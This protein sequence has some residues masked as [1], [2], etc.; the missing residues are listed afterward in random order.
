M[1][2][3]KQE[4]PAQ[5]QILDDDGGLRDDAE[6]LAL[7]D[8]AIVDMYTDM[9]LARRFD[10]RVVSLN[11]QGRIGSFP[12]MYGHE[13]AQIASAHAL[14]DEDWVIPSYRDHGALMAQGFPLRNILLYYMG[15]EAGNAVPDD[16]NALPINGSVGSQ[17]LHAT[18]MAWA[19][20]LRDDV[21]SVYCCYFGDGATSQGFAQEAWNFAG[22]FDTPNVFFCQNNGWAIS[23]PR[24][25]QT[26]AETI[27]QKAHA[28][29]FDGVQVDG[30]DPLAVYRITREAVRRAK[31]P[32]PDQSRPMLIEAVLYRLGAHS[33]A[34]DPSKYRPEDEVEKWRERD[35]LVRFEQFLRDTGRLDDERQDALETEVDAQIDEAIDA[36]ESFEAA[37]PSQMFEHVYAN[38]PDHLQDQAAVLESLR[39]RHGDDALVED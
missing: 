10:R 32:D 29:G 16:V 2:T 36:A 11:R 3:T 7:S 21:D 34:D 1:G 24:D 35:P 20:V 17:L 22:V 25:R 31:D 9:L 12:P 6:E 19:D 14:A 5:L 37:D 4:L 15:Y 13:A 39:E 8:D 27:A 26:A 30:M 28:F 18:G 23:V 38:T 33:T